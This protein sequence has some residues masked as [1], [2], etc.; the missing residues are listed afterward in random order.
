MQQPLIAALSGAAYGRDA[1]P[2][3]ARAPLAP[4]ERPVP[5]EPRLL[6]EQATRAIRSRQSHAASELALEV[7]AA[8]SLL[9]ALQQASRSYGVQAPHR[10]SP[11]RLRLWALELGGQPEVSRSRGRWM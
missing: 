6:V 1:E 5:P 3:V 4:A 9:V 2:E 11:R 8:A 10:V 7:D